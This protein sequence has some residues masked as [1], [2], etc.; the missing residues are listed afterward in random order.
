MKRAGRA[1]QDELIKET[2]ISPADI[3]FKLAKGIHGYDAI[4]P[5]VVQISLKKTGLWPMDY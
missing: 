5:E 4:T 2:D 1:L 3:N